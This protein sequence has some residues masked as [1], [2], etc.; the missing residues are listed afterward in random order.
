MYGKFNLPKN[1]LVTNTPDSSDG[2]AE[3]ALTG[4]LY[5][6]RGLNQMTLNRKSF[7]PN[8]NYIL[9]LSYLLSI[10][11]NLKKMKMFMNLNG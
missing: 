8:I 7:D 10:L 4:I 11:E 6:L 3:Y 5:L 2:V 9:P 1:T